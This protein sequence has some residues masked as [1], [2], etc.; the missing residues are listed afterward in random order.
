MTINPQDFPALYSEYYP[1]IVGYLRRLVGE[2]E[3]EDVAQE[4][5]VKVSRSLESFRGESQLSTWIYRIA[6]NTAMDHLRKP[7]TKRSARQTSGAEEDEDYYED[8]VVDSAPLHDTLLIRKDMNDC[9]RGLVNDLPENY[10][11][12]LVLADL[13]G[14]TN[15]EI[16]D[17]LGLSLDT[18]KIRL[19][20]AR[21]QLKKSMDQAC[22]LYRDHRNE[23][24]CDRKS[25]TLE[26]KRI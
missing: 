6:T 16:G 7:S 24:S 17:V 25:A 9:I 3:A 5:F 8:T 19:H 18:V 26:F 14:F 20:R 4:T 15:A 21:V 22:H 12:V 1:K 2:A 23:F 13:E 10:R 11:A